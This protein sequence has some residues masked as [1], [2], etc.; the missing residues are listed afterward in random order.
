VF[1]LSSNLNDEKESNMG[2]GHSAGF[3]FGMGFGWLI[4]L[5]L[6]GIFFYLLFRGVGSPDRS[7]NRG[8]EDAGKILRKRLA[9]GEIDEEEYRR[10]RAILE[11]EGNATS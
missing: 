5:G 3:G 9:R 6:M 10:K 11:E 4:P 2:M 7:E 1:I 8:E